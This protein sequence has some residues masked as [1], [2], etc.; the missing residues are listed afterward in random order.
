LPACSLNLHPLKAGVEHVLIDQT[1]RKWFIG[2]VAALAVATAA[3]IP[4]ALRSPQG[5]RGGSAMGL[6]Y[7]V[8]GSLFML[9]AGLLGL[10]K[11]FPVWRIG[12]AQTWM[13]GHLW[14]GL[15]SFPLILFH[16]GF[17]FGGSLTRML[18]WL[19]LFVW[20]SGILGAALQHFM[21]RFQTAQLPMETIYEQIDRVRGQLAEE[22]GQLVEETC[23][24]LEGEVSRASERQRAM[25]ASAGTQGGLTVASGL[26]ANQQVSAQLRQFLDD[27]MRPY[28]ERAG[29]HSARLG[30][31]AEA[32]KMFEQF[33]VLLPP[34]LHSNL[35]DLENICEEKRQLDL[36]SRLHKVLH[37]WLLVHIPFSYAL[38]LLGAVHAVVALR[39]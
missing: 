10:R 8:A 6:A 2:S 36:Q 32:Q 15:L 30:H 14:L 29:A 18:M 21:P 11:K 1:H 28:L 25:S 39:F 16:G 35:D 23:S 34:E 20:V 37:G 5:P 12:R 3:Y 13:R 24:A 22:A 4:Y 26:Q 9:F 7:G 31:P 17:H 19:F 33:R 38:I 27:E